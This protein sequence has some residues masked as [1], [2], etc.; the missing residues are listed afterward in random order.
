[1]KKTLLLLAGIITGYGVFAQAVDNCQNAVPISLTNGVSQTITGT[2]VGATDDGIEG[3]PMMWVAFTT[4]GGICNYEITVDYCNSPTMLLYYGNLGDV[5]GSSAVYTEPSVVMTCTSGMNETR[6]FSG[7]TPNTTYYMPI[8]GYYDDGLGNINDD[9]PFQIA[10]VANSACAPNN[11]ICSNTTP[12]TLNSGGTVTFSGTTIGATMNT[13]EEAPTVWE[14]ITLPAMAP[15]CTYDIDVSYCGS[16]TDQTIYYTVMTTNCNSGTEYNGDFST[17]II[18]LDNNSTISFTGI[19][20][21]TYYIPI[22]GAY[23][24]G[25]GNVNAAGNYVINVSASSSCGPSNDLCS[26]VTPVNLVAGV[27]QTVSG[28]TVGANMDIG[29]DYPLVWEAFTIPSGSGCTY[30]VNVSYCNS[31]TVLALFGNLANSCGVGAL[32]LAP[33]PMQPCVSGN[34]SMVFSGLQSG[35]TYYLPVLG[36]YD[37]GTYYNP[38]GSYAIDL[39]LEETCSPPNDICANVTPTTLQNNI[40]QV[41]NGT[42]AGAQMNGNEIVPEVWE[43]FTLPGSSAGCNYTVELSFCGTNPVPAYYENLYTSCGLTDPIEGII[44]SCADGNYI[45]TFENMA[46][47]TY[48]YPIVGAYEGNPEGPYTMSVTASAPAPATPTVSTSGNTSFCEGGSVTLTSSAS[49]GNLWSN[50]ATTSSITVSQSGSYTVSISSGGCPSALSI[51]VVVNV[52]P[53]AS[54]D[55]VTVTPGPAGYVSASATNPQN[56]A[57]YLW[58]FGDASGS[59]PGTNPQAHTYI[60]NGV[61]VVSLVVSNECGTNSSSFTITIDNVPPTG[62]GELGVDEQELHLYPNPAGASIQLQNNGKLHIRNLTIYDIVGKVVS[63]NKVDDAPLYNLDV[64]HLGSGKYILR[65]DTDKGAVSRK[66]EIL[67]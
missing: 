35:M 38:E 41:F 54:V 28:T 12:T 24:D 8:V 31:P 60:A 57:T 34:N 45:L 47:G 18:C 59:N 64:S 32:F 33:G 13:N 42:T 3:A 11:D 63:R 23:S 22:L 10:I 43:A 29:E 39:T 53:A 15:G 46:P 25:L 67:R 17:E 36:Y 14:S 6:T 51:P 27:T 66:F 5:C 1:M 40:T 65:I 30:S 2:T 56:V 62:I 52:T 7:L 49:S 37:D 58:D 26:N 16:P 20:P 44:T 48:Y 55:G 19:P 50:G 21:G 61:Y 4:P 9:G